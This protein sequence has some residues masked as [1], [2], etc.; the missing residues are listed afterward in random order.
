[1][2]QRRNGL[3]FP[4][5]ILFLYNFVPTSKEMCRHRQREG[6]WFVLG[7]LAWNSSCGVWTRCY[8]QMELA[9]TSPEI[10]VECSCRGHKIWRNKSRRKGEGEEVKSKCRLHRINGRVWSIFYRLFLG[11]H[12]RTRISLSDVDFLREAGI[13]R[14][15]YRSSQKRQITGLSQNGRGHAFF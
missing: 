11:T 8:R 4:D 5:P 12:A 1:M 6:I 9:V 10:F 7:F 3:E 2:R 13:G 15:F 14:L